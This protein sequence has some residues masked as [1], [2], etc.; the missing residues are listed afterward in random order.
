MLLLIIQLFFS[1]SS[2]KA[3]EASFNFNFSTGYDGWIGDFA[4]YFVGQEAFFELAWG[5]SNIPQRLP[6]EEQLKGMFLSGNN[7]SDD[8]VMFIKRQL[9]GLKPNT[10]Y[11][12]TFFVTI[13]D[14]IPPG[15]FGIGGSPGES[16]YVKV[17][18]SKKQP[19]KVAEGP[20]YRLNVDIGFQSNGGKNAIVV[21]NLANPLVNPDDPQYEPKSLT[22]EIPLRVKTDQKGRLWVFV[23]TDSAFEGSTLYYISNISV[24]AKRAHQGHLC[25]CGEVENKF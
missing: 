19:V 3:K 1:F 9:E 12:L 10:T 11:D 8:L 15:Q 13:Q 18:G 17:G 21:G 4:D 23:G 6:V 7:H 16:V 2:V 25:K 22:N 24:I 14:N 5:W 20:I